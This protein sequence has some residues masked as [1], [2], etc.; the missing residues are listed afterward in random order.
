MQ[1]LRT[2]LYVCATAIL[3]PRLVDAFSIID[4]THYLDYLP[5]RMEGNWLDSYCT[6]MIIIIIAMNI[7]IFIR[8]HLSG[9][10]PH[11]G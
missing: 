9:R 4:Y 3:W 1:L 6:C 2:L 5:N 11:E 10:L 7:I 8:S